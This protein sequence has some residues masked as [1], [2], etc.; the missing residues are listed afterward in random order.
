MGYSSYNFDVAKQVELTELARQRFD[1]NS[2]EILTPTLKKL[3]Y[4]PIYAELALPVLDSEFN[5]IAAIPVVVLPTPHLDVDSSF[6]FFNLTPEINTSRRSDHDARYKV[7]WGPIVALNTNLHTSDTAAMG[8]LTWPKKSGPQA[9]GLSSPRLLQGLSLTSGVDLYTTNSSALS[10]YTKLSIQPKFGALL[11]PTI[12]APIRLGF[13]TDTHVK[14]EAALSALSS[15]VSGEVAEVDECVPT[16]SMG[17]WA[18]FGY[19][20]KLS[21]NSPAEFHPYHKMGAG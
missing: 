5:A 18:T 19:V 2:T 17:G 15:L 12:Q 9:L 21:V 16:H 6:M 11:S 20:Q 8:S 10:T 1:K 14:A 3:Q 4:K 7:T 13:P